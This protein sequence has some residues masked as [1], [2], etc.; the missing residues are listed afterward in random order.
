M[1]TDPVFIIESI[2][3]KLRM[4]RGIPSPADV[5]NHVQTSSTASTP[6]L[7]ATVNLVIRRN[8]PVP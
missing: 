1:D 8:L 6:V 5:R 4:H 7:G 3:G 2:D